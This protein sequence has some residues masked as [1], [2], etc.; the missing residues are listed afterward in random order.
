M[1]RPIRHRILFSLRWHCSVW[2]QDLAIGLGCHTPSGFTSNLRTF[3]RSIHP[4]ELTKKIRPQRQK[5]PKLT[6]GTPWGL[7]TGT[8]PNE[9]TMGR[10][11]DK[12]APV[13]RCGESHDNGE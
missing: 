12:R 9:K 7:Q 13:Q 8:Q 2:T 10:E 4:D 6:I 1:T 5:L 11:G 3:Y